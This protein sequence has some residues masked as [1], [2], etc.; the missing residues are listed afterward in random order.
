MGDGQARH[1]APASRPSV[2]VIGE[3]S[4]QVEESHPVLVE[5]KINLSGYQLRHLQPRM[6]RAFR[7]KASYIYICLNLFI[8]MG[9][10]IYICTRIFLHEDSTFKVC[11]MAHSH[12]D[13]HLGLFA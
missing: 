11:F 12:R 13:I 3:K 2:Q 5:S 4:P 9:Q 1:Q 7:P 10:F 8:Y 6:N